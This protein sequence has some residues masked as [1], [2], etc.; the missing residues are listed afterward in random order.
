MRTRRQASGV[1]PRAS[2]PGG[3]PLTIA[4]AL[5]VAG[6]LSAA[7]SA[8]GHRQDAIHEA[9]AVILVNPLVGSPFS[10]DNTRDALVNLQTEAQLVTSD[11]VARLVDEQLASGESLSALLAAVSVDVPPN[12]QLIRV[13]ARAATADQAVRRAQAFA[14]TYLKS[15]EARSRS[16]LADRGAQLDEQIR[17]RSASQAAAASELDRAAAGGTRAVLLQQE[18]IEI[19]SQIGHLRTQRAAVQAESSSPGQV[20]TPATPRHGPPLGWTVLGALAGLL[21]GLGSAVALGAAR[22][23]RDPALRSDEAMQQALDSLR[24]PF[25]GQADKPDDVRTNLLAHQPC[26]SLVL[27]LATARADP[28]ALACGERLAASL[29]RS[30]RQT[31]LVDMIGPDPT[32]EGNSWRSAP[33]ITDLLLGLAAPRQLLDEAPSAA[34]TPGVL[35]PGSSPEALDNLV[36]APRMQDLVEELRKRSDVLL[37][38]AG[39]VHDRRT[40]ALMVHADAVLIECGETTVG[41]LTQ[42]IAEVRRAGTSVAGVIRTPR[43]RRVRGVRRSTRRHA[44]GVNRH[45]TARPEKVRL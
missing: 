22:T 2:A 29:A 40:R 35:G 43:V 45:P 23:R 1:R 11:A 32:D 5:V 13:T 38:V 41:E 26:Q 21:V 4:L 31:L 16:E 6:A 15:R 3:R 8:W 34:G 10:P 28:G 30:E 42:T 12:T 25:L 44:P 27:V 33:G 19:T 9:T 39:A 20:V 24:V 14:E 37:M 36:S 18:L 17:E 7:G